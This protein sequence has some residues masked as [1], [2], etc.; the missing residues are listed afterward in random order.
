M[1]VLYRC[2]TGRAVRH[3]PRRRALRVPTAAEEPAGPEWAGHGGECLYPEE[4]EEPA[5]PYSALVR[6]SCTERLNYAWS[7]PLS[8][9]AYCGS[10]ILI[11]YKHRGDAENVFWEAAEESFE[12][13]L[14]E[15]DDAPAVS[16]DGDHLPTL[17]YR[18]TR[19]AAA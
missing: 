6:A 1:C 18:L 2:L 14:I 8:C 5:G 10:Q 17:L 19:R 11:S 16:R 4:E 7:A 15:R 3:A 12:V 9:R 13:R